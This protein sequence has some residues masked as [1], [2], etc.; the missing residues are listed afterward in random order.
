MDQTQT[1]KFRV[2]VAALCLCAVQTGCLRRR[3]TI[4]SNPPGARVFVDNYEIGRTPCSTDFIYYGTR[5]IRLVKDGYETLTV[6][7]PIPAPWYDIPP[8][9]FVTE[10]VVPTKI[11]DHRV[12]DFVLSPQALV[13]SEQ[14]VSRAESVRQGSRGPAPLQPM[15]PAGAVLPPGGAGPAL[16]APPPLAPTEPLPAPARAP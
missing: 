7:Q 11:H 16:L 5:Q 9:D 14:L 12:V 13:P 1:L 3:L 8:I 10:N 2:V 15:P 4:R 6:Q